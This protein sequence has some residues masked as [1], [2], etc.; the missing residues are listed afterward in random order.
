MANFI[1]QLGPAFQFWYEDG[2]IRKELYYQYGDKI[3]EWCPEFQFWY[4]DGKKD[5]EKWFG[6]GK[7]SD[8]KTITIDGKEVSEETI[9]KA[10]K[11]Y[12]N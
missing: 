3:L 9:L 11:N 12:F 1:D 4:E 10:L 5:K 6:N 2:N 8:S 7:D